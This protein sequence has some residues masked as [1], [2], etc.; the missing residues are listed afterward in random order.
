MFANSTVPYSA[1]GNDRGVEGVCARRCRE[2]LFDNLP[3][4]ELRARLLSSPPI[5][6]KRRIPRSGPAKKSLK[7]LPIRLGRKRRRSPPTAWA[8]NNVAEIG[9]AAWEAVVAW[10]AVGSVFLAAVIRAAVAVTLVVAVIPVAEV[11]RAAGDIRQMAAAKGDIPT[12]I[13]AAA[14]EAPVQ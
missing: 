2:K 6:G 7:S 9:A 5:P 3:F 13:L 14:V 12:M 10:E 4:W 1:C 11:I 8:N